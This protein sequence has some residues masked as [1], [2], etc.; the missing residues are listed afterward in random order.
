VGFEIAVRG[1]G[2]REPPDL[3]D[4]SL[5]SEAELHQ[6]MRRVVIDRTGG[7]S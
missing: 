3:D 2:E 4:V 1:A 7:G 6:I 5:Y